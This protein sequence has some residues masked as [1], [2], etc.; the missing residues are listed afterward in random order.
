MNMPAEELR[1]EAAVTR[2]SLRWRSWLRFEERGI[3]AATLLFLVVGAISSP[4]FLTL[5]NLTGILQSLTFLGFLAIG[6]GLTLM[7]GEIDISVGSVF[8]LAAVVS[9]LS[10]HR[11]APLWLAILQGLGTGLGCGFVNGAVAELIHVPAVVVTLA[12]LGVYRALA[13]V[14]AGGSPVTGM[15]PLPGFFD[16]FGQGTVGGVS[17]I[18]L[19]F[20]G[21]AT[22]AELALR[23]TAFGFR[24][25]AIGS[26]PLAA[27]LVGFHVGRTRL[28]LLVLSGFMAALSGVCSVAY[29]HTAGPTAGTGYELSVLAAVI[30]G[31]VQ[32]T[33]GRGSIL[34][35]LLGL[36]VIGII[37]NL[38]VLWGIPPSWTQ[39]VS[40]MV[41]IASMALTWVSRRDTAASPGRSAT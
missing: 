15:P 40:G 6:V 3:A 33:G 18:T 10:L 19:L 9:A 1:G 32:L 27:H 28:V 2:G 8:G 5:D 16:T 29:L 13:L 17:I 39:G 37:Q 23:R 22:V 14:L 30:I 41:L 24:L 11:G 31:G 21:V 35:I 26:N 36:A 25:L 20:F 7:A 12:T 4:Y 38:I 34:G